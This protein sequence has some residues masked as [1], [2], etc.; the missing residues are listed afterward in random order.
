MV[1]LL[2][3][4]CFAFFL[5][6]VHCADKNE[7]RILSL[8]PMTGEA[9]PGGWSCLVPVHMAID[10]INAH[11]DLLLGYTL[12]FDYIDHEVSISYRYYQYT[13]NM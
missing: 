9:W 7:L 6:C 11:P 13:V 12:T 2:Q 8:L 5:I 4:L 10:G 1:F 3:L